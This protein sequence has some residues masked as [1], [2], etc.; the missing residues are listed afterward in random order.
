[1]T[2]TVSDCIEK[3]DQ[4]ALISCLILI[5]VIAGFRSSDS[6][7]VNL[8]IKPARVSMPWK[9]YAVIKPSNATHQEMVKRSSMSSAVD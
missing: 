6:L 4:F 8:S 1:L 7:S 3:T 5:I 2:T 9:D